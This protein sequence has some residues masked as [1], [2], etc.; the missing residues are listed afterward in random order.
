MAPV[1]D[2]DSPATTPEAAGQVRYPRWLWLVGAV[3]VAIV[4]LAITGLVYIDSGDDVTGGGGVI[5]QLI[6]PRNAQIV[7]QQEVG[8]RLAPG[9]D[10]ELTVN[11]TPIPTTQLD[12]TT[13]LNLI[14][15]QPG[16]NKVIEQLDAGENCVLATFWRVETGPDESSTFSWC[17]SVV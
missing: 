13:G 8:L 11:G 6:P 1:P 15:F 16:P 14:T 10:A 5:Q 17:F 9:Y 12:K 7:Q 2:P 3:V 4:A